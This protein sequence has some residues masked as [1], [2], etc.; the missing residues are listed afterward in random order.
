MSFQIFLVVTIT[1]FLLLLHNLVTLAV[2]TPVEAAITILRPYCPA[3]M[4]RDW[5]RESS[6]SEYNDTVPA[7]TSLVEPQQQQRQ[8]QV[9]AEIMDLGVM[10]TVRRRMLPRYHERRVVSLP[11][12][13]AADFFT[14][15]VEFGSVTATAGSSSAIARQYGITHS[16]NRD[17]QD[18][19]NKNI[20]S[21]N[22]NDDGNDQ[23][24]FDTSSA[25]SR[26]VRALQKAMS[27]PA[28]ASSAS[29][30]SSSSSFSSSSALSKS[31][32]DRARFSS[33]RRS[34]SLLNLRISTLFKLTSF[35][36]SA[37]SATAVD[38]H[39]YNVNSGHDDHESEGE[40][41]SD[42]SHRRRFRE[43]FHRREKSVTELSQ[44]SL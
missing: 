17:R 12:P 29:S 32:L 10:T 22:D 5:E 21:G 2:M 44:G 23:P 39:A 36:S 33:S 18:H 7:L 31:R 15:A 24:E 9:A 20:N 41:L 14:N 28:P 38:E 19:D 37:T 42:A 26:I 13:A 35:S 43:I 40:S 25:S 3:S 1:R 27:S 4:F 6:F 34:P 30:S 8:R 16:V 11:P